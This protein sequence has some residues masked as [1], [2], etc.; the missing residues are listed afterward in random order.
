MAGSLIAMTPV[1]ILYI[2]SQ[3]Y[4]VTGLSAGAVKG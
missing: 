4:V 1:V 2:L 3:R